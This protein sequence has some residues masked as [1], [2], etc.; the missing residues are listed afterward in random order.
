ML[1]ILLL[2]EWR[3]RS[4]EEKKTHESGAARKGK[5]G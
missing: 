1:L 3:E 5:E 4:G 2:Y